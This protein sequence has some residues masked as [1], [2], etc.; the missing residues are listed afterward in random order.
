[1]VNVDGAF[2]VGPAKGV[3]N[4]NH[5]AHLRRHVGRVWLDRIRPTTR[6]WRSAPHAELSRARIHYGRWSRR[7][8]SGGGRNR[9]C[10]RKR[11]IPMTRFTRWR[12][13][14]L[15]AGVL[16]ALGAASFLAPSLMP[17]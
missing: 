17:K 10:P 15:I 3:E 8:G 16:A 13:Y 7:A 14:A 6:R 1:M 4:F 12:R 5:P 9:H 11:R 2:P